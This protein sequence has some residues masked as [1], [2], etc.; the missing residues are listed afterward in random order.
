MRDPV[1][2]TKSYTAKNGGHENMN[3]NDSDVNC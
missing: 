1:K 2:V 3:K